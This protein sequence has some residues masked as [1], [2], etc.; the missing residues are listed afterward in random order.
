MASIYR[1]KNKYCVVYRYTDEQ[2]NERQKWETFDTN[3][4]ARKRKC[5]IEYQQQNGTFMVYEAKTVADL[6]NDY[7]TI[8]GVNKWAMSTYEGRK[9]LI[10]HYI[11]PVIGQIELKDIN[12]RIIEK[13][14]LDLLNMKFVS[15]YKSPEKAVSANII[16]EIHKLLRCAFN[17]AVKWELISKNPCLNATVPKAENKEREIWD[18]ET[19]YKAISLCDDE[20]LKLAI[21]LA[22]ACSLRIG[23]MLGLTWDC[24]E[25]SEASIAAGEAYIIVN[26]ELQRVNKDVMEKLGEK[27]VIKKF[28]A[29]FSRNTTV[30]VLKTPKTASS[31]R[32]IYLPKTVALMLRKRYDDIQELIDL[33]GE[34]YCDYNLVFCSPNGRPM[35]SQI[36]TRALQKLI[37]EN[38]LPHIV[39]HS[40]RHSS[41]T[42]KLKLNGGDVKSVQGDSGHSQVK[43]ITD[44]YSHIIDEDRKYNAAKFEEVFYSKYENLHSENLKNQQAPPKEL[45]VEEIDNESEMLLKLIQNPE[46]KDLIKKLAS[47]L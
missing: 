24:I 29:V 40:L 17:Q 2:G 37:R 27:D 43:M 36:I 19:L 39:F 13:Y 6:L 12:T 31:V 22:F 46:M 38:N 47:S 5:E 3:T 32:K 28:P 8:Y 23:E 33:F 44:V 35:E 18:S 26:K 34:E 4:A 42:Y 9:S 25:I 16:R 21:N 10:S 45:A 30:L 1:R 7:V 11:N 41:V 20:I 14:Y 15:S